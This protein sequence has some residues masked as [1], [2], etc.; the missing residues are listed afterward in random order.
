MKVTYSIQKIFMIIGIAAVILFQRQSDIA[1]GAEFNQRKNKFVLMETEGKDP[2]VSFDGTRIA[3][4]KGNNIYILDIATE[5]EQKITN[6]PEKE[7]RNNNW[8]ELDSYPTIIEQRSA[9]P[10]PRH[11]T[12]SPRSN[13]IAYIVS[14]TAS[15]YIIEAEKGIS[16]VEIAKGIEFLS[17]SPDGEYLLLGNSG[18]PP[19]S[20]DVLSIFSI[21]DKTVTTLVENEALSLMDSVWSNDA[22]TITYVSRRMS[23]N[24]RVVEDIHSISIMDHKS[25]ILEM[26]VDFPLVI[27]SPNQR[28]VI[29]ARDHGILLRDLKNNRQIIIDNT[30][31]ASSFIWL[32]DSEK[33]YFSSDLYPGFGA[34][35]WCMEGL[36]K[37]PVKLKKRE[38]TTGEDGLLKLSPDGKYIAFIRLDGL[39]SGILYAM[40]LASEK[41]LKIL[42][43]QGRYK[44][45]D[46]SFCW[47]PVGNKILVKGKESFM[48][49][50]SNFEK[51][52]TR[53]EV[54]LNRKKYVPMDNFYSRDRN[55]NLAVLREGDYLVINNDYILKLNTVLGKGH[56]ERSYM[57]NFG[58]YDKDW[59]MVNKYAIFGAWIINGDYSDLGRKIHTYEMPTY[60]G[61][62]I[63]VEE[64]S[65]VRDVTEAKIKIVKD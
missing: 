39:G 11:L 29:S 34:G 15:V 19:L 20:S 3:F 64:I 50:D 1:K 43:F 56:G 30:V 16:P 12:W 10:T 33:F 62:T 24:D 57:T 14:G 23:D 61:F 51:A 58:I 53:G 49:I 46:A 44:L 18:Y 31:R 21:V 36:D 22:K 38:L 8:K 28:Y 54:F 2:T 55:E 13:Y 37:I 47:F 35:I 17:W 52:I 6:I 9:E 27:P 4:S 40:D 63:S 7:E 5:V 65:Q 32:S 42:P 25:R 26:D 41:I 59:K 48:I 60:E 45:K